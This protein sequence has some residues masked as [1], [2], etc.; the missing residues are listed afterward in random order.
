MCAAENKPANRW[1]HIPIQ[2]VGVFFCVYFYFHVPKSGKALLLLGGIAA[3]MMLMD[4]RPLHK[5]IYI[6]IILGLVLIENHALDKERADFAREDGNRRKEENDR[7]QSIADGIQATIAN[8]DKQFAATMGRTNQILQNVTGGDSFGFVVPQPWGEQIPLLVWNHGE[9]P[10]TGVTITIARTQEPDWGSAFY[11]PIF[12]GTIGPQDHAPVPGF[13][14][15]RPDAKSGQD[16][17]WIMIAAQNGT[18]S[19]SLYFRKNQ[20]GTVPW[21]YSYSVSRPV[22]LTKAKGPIP[23][24]ATRME[25]LLTRRWSDEVDEPH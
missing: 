22:T 6:S 2:S 25:P 19:Q 10:L 7:F 11:R 4:M 9:Q 5:G 8:S 1:F 24:G 3:V 12:I 14:L 20:K 23:K 21:A 18:V 13:L 17:Y 15:P 16:H